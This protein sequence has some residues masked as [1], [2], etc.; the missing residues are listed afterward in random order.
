MGNCGYKLSISAFRYKKQKN[1]S[2]RNCNHCS[3]KSLQTS[4]TFINA[5]FILK[6]NTM[7][8]E[9]HEA[10]YLINYTPDDIDSMRSGLQEYASLIESGDAF[11]DDYIVA[12]FE[13]TVEKIDLSFFKGHNDLIG[14]LEQSCE[15][16]MD[17][18]KEE[19]N[20]KECVMTETLFFLC[21]AKHPE[22]EADLKKTCE[23]IV[24]FARKTNDSSKM[25]ITCETA[26]GIEPLQIVASIYP[27]YGYLFASFFVP[28]W[29]DEHMFNSLGDLSNWSNKIGVNEHTIKAFCYCDNKLARE[30]MLGFTSWNGMDEDMFIDTKF[31]LVKNLRKSIK[32]MDN[33]KEQLVN[34]FKDQPLLGEIYENYGEDVCVEDPITIILID[35]LM[36]VNPCDPWDDDFDLDEFLSIRLVHKS[37]VLEVEEIH[38]LMNEKSVSTQAAETPEEEKAPEI[39]ENTQSLLNWKDFFETALSNGKSIWEYIIKGD[40]PE[41]LNSL[42]EQDILKLA[43][44]KKCALYK[45]LKAE[46]CYD[47]GDFLDDLERYVRRLFKAFQNSETRAQIGSKNDD[48]TLI[49]R[50][51]DVIYR[52]CGQKPFE[53]D[54]IEQV[55]EE[56]Q[57]APSAEA[58]IARFPVDWKKVFQKQL[59]S[60]VGYHSVIT[61]QAMEELMVLINQNREDAI[62]YLPESCFK[63]MPPNEEELDD[64]DYLP[65]SRRGISPV[66]IVCIALYIYKTDGFSQ[67]N[68]KLSEAT[69]AYIDHYGERIF[70]SALKDEM[71]VATDGTMKEIANGN[72][73]SNVKDLNDEKEKHANWLEIKS[74]LQKG[75]QFSNQQGG[76]LEA[77]EFVFQRMNKH[78]DIEDRTPVSEYQDN[79]NLLRDL[80][81][82]IHKTLLFAQLV[83]SDDT[84]DFNQTAGRFLKLIY[85]LGPVRVVHMIAKAYNNDKGFTS[86]MAMMM[87]LDTIKLQIMPPEAYLGY[88]LYQYSKANGLDNPER[89]IG[90]L[91]ELIEAIQQGDR[92]NSD[93]LKGFELLSF[94]T[95][96]DIINYAKVNI[97]GDVFSEIYA[98]YFIKRFQRMLMSGYVIADPEIY[99]QRKLKHLGFN[100]QH[101]YWD[102]WKK[103]KELL[104]QILNEVE[105]NEACTLSKH[106]C[107]RAV[108][109]KSGWGYLILQ[110]Q[111]DKIIPIIGAKLLSLIQNGF[112]EE[113]MYSAQT[114]AI[115]IDEACPQENIDEL[116]QLLT[117]D[118]KAHIVKEVSTYLKGENSLE[119]IEDYLRFGIH[120][121][122]IDSFTNYSEYS[123][124]DVVHKLDIS[125][126]F[127]GT[128][129][130]A[131]TSEDL[132]ERNPDQSTFEYYSELMESEIDRYAIFKYLMD[133]KEM[134]CISNLALKMD[135]SS[136]IKQEKVQ[137]QMALLAVVSNYPQYHAFVMSCEDSGVPKFKKHV[138]MLVSKYNMK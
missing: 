31:P 32:A 138:K 41:R 94:E 28:N 39:D 118:H 62:N 34:R 105:T 38:A 75:E 59:K 20:I 130:M 68:D 128:N 25:W 87:T 107:E 137:E 67:T 110:K 77:F 74:Y 120:K 98:T 47:M 103:H 91:K 122:G 6:Y 83:A 93:L 55:C 92:E 114:H 109:D 4:S 5:D 60:F 102:K 72:F 3:S 116:K 48:K 22:L 51:S 44:K 57:A 119:N 11:E 123:L 86:E 9:E 40:H 23:T 63:I 71:S 78:M 69:K 12:H 84:F 13:P 126:R 27:E 17:I 124:N 73:R 42:E 85:K 33:F 104:Q 125:A 21:A 117:V 111:E 108:Y 49:L 1:K 88:Q 8:L 29:D 15:Y 30:M 70:L 97:G 18:S 127:I 99:F 112:D 134:R 26:F 135:I 46:Y 66:E 53:D 7:K 16:Y 19:D 56:Y 80:N 65:Y 106:E 95:Q 37:A 115:I 121:S 96:L 52:L 14:F 50:F 136:F 64:A 36:S 58:F 129:A 10:E 90:M 54:Y 131:L 79:V 45:D 76:E 61:L 133:K 82:K 100:A 81:D 2:D 113:S 43:K 132:L 101:I 89:F 35:M 24:D